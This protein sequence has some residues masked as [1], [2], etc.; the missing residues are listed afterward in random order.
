LLRRRRTEENQIAIVGNTGNT[1]NRKLMKET[2]SQNQQACQ[3]KKY[4][5]QKS[6]NVSVSKK[7]SSDVRERE[8]ERAARID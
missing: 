4:T 6:E 7:T 5:S 8:R 2:K 3:K 1:G